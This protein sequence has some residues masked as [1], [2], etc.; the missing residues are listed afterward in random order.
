MVGAFKKEIYFPKGLWRDFWTGEMVEGGDSAIIEPPEG[1][2]GALYLREGAIVPLGPIMQYRGEKPLDE[3]DVLLFPGN[4]ESTLDF[5]EDDGVSFKA[6]ENN[7]FSTTRIAMSAAGGDSLMV[8]I[9]KPEGDFE[10]RPEARTWNLIVGLE[11]AP[12]EVSVDGVPLGAD[13][14]QWNESR[15]EVVVSAL[16]SDGAAIHV[17]IS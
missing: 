1:R 9:G 4:S 5:Y 17:E 2:G 16:H 13:R 6:F 11:K 3:M 7:E 8:D 12:E 10:G 14:F 15:K